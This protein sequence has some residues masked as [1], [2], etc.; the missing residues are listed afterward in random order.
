MII[1]TRIFA[2]ELAKFP[3]RT[4]SE[5]VS[6]IQKYHRWLDNGLF[7]I[8]EYKQYIILKGY[9]NKKRVRI[10]VSRHQKSAYIPLVLFKKESKDGWNIRADFDPTTYIRHAEK[11]IESDEYEVLEI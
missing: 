3:K 8:R 9:L 1:I 6:I 5:V 4:V 10:I 11:C 7:E 2:R